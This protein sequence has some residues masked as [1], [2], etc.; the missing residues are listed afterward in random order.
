MDSIISLN[1]LL[2]I[3]QPP[4]TAKPKNTQSKFH[5]PLQ[6]IKKHEMYVYGCIICLKEDNCLHLCWDYLES[7]QINNELLK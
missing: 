4:K 6:F 7:S 5:S 1:L 2:P 3:L